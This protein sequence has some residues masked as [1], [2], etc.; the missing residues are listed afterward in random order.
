MLG[1]CT[2]SI[3]PPEGDTITAT[4]GSAPRSD[5]PY[6]SASTRTSGTPVTHSSS[7]DPSPTQGAMDTLLQR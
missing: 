3:T 5:P 1:S 2:K 4:V 7:S 6:I